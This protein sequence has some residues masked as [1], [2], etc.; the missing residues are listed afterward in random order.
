MRRLMNDPWDLVPPR[1]IRLMRAPAKD[2]WNG[3]AWH[4]GI[5]ALDTPSSRTCLNVLVER[6]NATY[7]K[8]THWIQE[9]SSG[10]PEYQNFAMRSSSLRFLGQK[11]PHLSDRQRFPIANFKKQPPVPPSEPMPLPRERQPDGR[12]PTDG[13]SSQRSTGAMT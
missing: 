8:D 11:A 10:D 5:W 3:F 6:G 4:A 13:R 9:D 2:P 12:W 1:M 7:G